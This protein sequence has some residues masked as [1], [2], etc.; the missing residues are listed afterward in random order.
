MGND[1][2]NKV[3]GSLINYAECEFSSKSEVVCFAS[4]LRSKR[5]PKIMKFG[6]WIEDFEY[7]FL[8]FE[9]TKTEFG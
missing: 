2:F 8:V 3:K 1:D 5:S 9:S 6:G 7:N 4:V